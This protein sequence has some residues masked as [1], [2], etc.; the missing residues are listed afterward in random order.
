MLKM[1]KGTTQK[2]IT[3]EMMNYY[4]SIMMNDNR[5]HTQEMNYVLQN[6]PTL[7]TREQ[8]ESVL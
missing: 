1:V 6:I 5:D 3:E 4:H 8:H 7:V 2:D